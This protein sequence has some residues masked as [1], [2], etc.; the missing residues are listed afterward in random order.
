VAFVAE[1]VIVRWSTGSAFGIKVRQRCLSIIFGAKRHFGCS[2]SWCGLEVWR[3]VEETSM[4]KD[5]KQD[6]GG[7]RRDLS[8][9]DSQ[10]PHR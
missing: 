6:K 5:N 1:V 2:F 3:G 7:A 8:L 4:A 10:A 9:Q